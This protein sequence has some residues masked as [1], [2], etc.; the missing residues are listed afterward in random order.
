MSAPDPAARDRMI[1]QAMRTGLSREQAAILTDMSKHAFEA[2]MATV[3]RILDTC[4]PELR[5]ALFASVLASFAGALREHL[6]AHWAAF[7]QADVSQDEATV[8][9]CQQRR[10]THEP[11]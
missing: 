9:S 7:Q 6:P 2:G 5:E 3:L 8:I 11:R 1:V 4:P 10:A